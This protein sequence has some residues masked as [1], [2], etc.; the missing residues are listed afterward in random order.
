MAYA[1][2]AQDHMAMPAMDSNGWLPLY[3]ALQDN[4]T[5]GAIKL[6]VKGNP[7]SVQVFDYQFSLLLHVVCE[8]CSVRVVKYLME[9]ND[10]Y[11]NHNDVNNNSILQYMPGRENY[12]VVNYLLEK[13]VA[14]V[15]R[16]NCVTKSSQF[17]CCVRL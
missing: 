7:S 9:L 15:S 2:Q 4:A 13:Q 3:H 14:F 8:S 6:L 1:N 12:D 17:I 10:S 5:L 11:L 16:R